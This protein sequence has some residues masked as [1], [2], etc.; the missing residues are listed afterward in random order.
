MVTK[1]DKNEKLAELLSSYLDEGDI[2][3]AEALATI[4]S[5][6]IEKRLAHGY[7]QTE[8]AKYMNVS[9]SMISKWESGDYNFTINTIASICSKLRL[10]LKVELR[11]KKSSFTTIPAPGFEI[12]NLREV[13]KPNAQDKL[14][15]AG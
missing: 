14:L 12:I 5:K 2:F 3:A 10:E 13:R 4:S 8:F 7:S 15:Q 1:V 6:I 11:E 9:Q